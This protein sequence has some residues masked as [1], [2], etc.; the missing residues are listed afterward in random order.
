MAHF[1]AVYSINISWGECGVQYNDI[2]LRMTINLRRQMF[3]LISPSR[4]WHV[5]TTLNTDYEEILKGA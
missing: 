2:E 4:H 3:F 5:S 1:Y